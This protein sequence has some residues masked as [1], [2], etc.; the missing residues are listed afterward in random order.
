MKEADLDQIFAQVRALEPPAQEQARRLL[1]A[2]VER[3]QNQAVLEAEF[4][5]PAYRTYLESELDA[6]EADRVTGRTYGLEEIRVSSA[7]RL[8]ALHG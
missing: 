4:D 2:L 6:A 8:K 3:V 1:V 7:A 5:D